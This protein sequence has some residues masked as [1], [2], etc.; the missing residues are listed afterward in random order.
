VQAEFSR[1]EE[2]A[3]AFWHPV[4]QA[5]WYSLFFVCGD[6]LHPREPDHVYA[7]EFAEAG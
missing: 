5:G 3:G 2:D 7:A 4:P 1:E 6:P